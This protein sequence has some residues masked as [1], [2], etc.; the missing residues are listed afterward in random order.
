MPDSRFYDRQGPF[1]LSDICAAAEAELKDAGA[2]GSQA[3]DPAPLTAAGPSE[4]AFF[5]ERKRKAELAATRALAVFVTSDQADLVPAGTQALICKDPYRSYAL[6]ARMFY[7]APCASPVTDPDPRFA[8]AAVSLQASV[9]DDVIIGNFTVVEPGAEIA[10]GCRIGHGVT[11]GRGVKLGADS[12]IMDQVTITHSL[13]GER[14]R[15]LTGARIGQRGFGTALGA[16]HIPLPQLGR[17]IIGDDVEIGANTTVDR[18]TLEDTVIGD[19]CKFDNLIQIAHNLQFGRGVAVAA[20]TG[21]AGSTKVGDY[22]IFGGH[23]AINGH[24]DIPPKVQ[25]GPMTGVM[26]APEQGQTV[27]GSPAMEAR[28]FMRYQAGL[29]RLVRARKENGKGST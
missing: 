15:A 28:E 16:E 5:R 1:T 8:Q 26:S 18:G 9:A 12:I 27:L 22:A 13:I 19:F 21:F 29:R 6:A 4:I 7:P 14:F 10:A 23:A 25:V 3:T 17:V 11:I 20:M 2:G 24:I